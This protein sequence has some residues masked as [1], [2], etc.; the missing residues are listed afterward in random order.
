LAN[1]DGAGSIADVV[2]HSVIS[3]TRG[4]P[5]ADIID[6]VGLMEAMRAAFSDD[7]DGACG[8]G[9]STGYPP[10]R[11]WIAD[12]HGV[13]ADQVLVTNGSMQAYALLSETLVMPGN[14]V[15]VEAPT[16]DR[17][18]A[19][20]LH[21]GAR[22]TPVPMEADGIDVDALET[23]LDDGLR[24]TLV[25]V[26]PTFQNPTGYTLSAGKRE[27]LLRGAAKHGFTVLEDDPYPAVRFE[28]EALPTMYSQDNRSVVYVSSFSKTICPG[29]RCGYLIGP[30]DLI[31]TLG[32]L[33]VKTYISPNTVAQAT[34]N[35][36]CRSGRFDHA[37][38]TLRT[39][40]RDRRDAMIAALRRELP[41]ARFTVP[42]GGY[43]IW[44]T[45]PGGVSVAEL[46]AE[47]TRHG[48]EFIKGTNFL[49][50]GGHDA[51]RL[52]FSGLTPELIDDGIRRLSSACHAVR[53]ARVS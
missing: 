45:L 17:T 10:L 47:A 16:Y 1:R 24:P 39:A 50:D 30:A 29:I 4:A 5:S 20:L 33:A 46:A 32:E 44:V 6:I 52:A 23:M 37:M 9:P 21:R 2:L 42:Q 12:H 18:L 41:D 8:Y 26:I 31:D 15:V 36:Y 34:V 35:Q 7:P 51:V 25:H 48:V 27:R 43:F 28:G 38:G 49:L 14:D 53:S 19:N 3:F 13:T 40:L 22:V 11:D